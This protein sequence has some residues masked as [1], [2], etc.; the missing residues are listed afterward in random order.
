MAPKMIIESPGEEEF[1]LL[2]AR[3]VDQGHVGVLGAL[4]EDNA[5][6]QKALRALTQ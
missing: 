6:V 4:P 3:R 5:M 2:V 1:V